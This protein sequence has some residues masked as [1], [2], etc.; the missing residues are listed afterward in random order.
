MDLQRCYNSSE[1]IFP[2]PPHIKEL[3][4]PFGFPEPRDPHRPYLS[5]NFVM[6]LDGR[7]SF[8]ELKGRTGGREVSRSREDRWLMD[9]LRAHHDG[10]LIGANTLRE[11][12]G[13][14]TRGWDFGIDDEQ[15]RAYREE[16]LGLAKQKII[17]LTG[18]GNV[19]VT[20]PVFDSPRVEP[21]IITTREGERT[22]R[23]QHKMLER[24]RRTNIISVGSGEGV[25]LATA[26]ELLRQEHGI[27]TLLCEG[28]P[29]LYGQLLG[30]QL[31]DEEF[32]T[33]SLQVLGETTKPGIERPTTY[34]NV[35][36]S[37]ETAPWFRLI[38]I[39]YALPYHAFFRHR[40]EG[41]RKSQE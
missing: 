7:A 20:L 9:F 35:S 1:D 14:D 22:L 13:T 28:G 3:Y 40:Y 34:G 24:E 41:R 2:L 10:L 37:P 21:W 6:G 38:S 30:E 18:S 19:D 4:G 15:L 33:I 32:R 8:R 31:I 27:R 29:T 11:E 16:T 17:I 26:V 39:H 36:Y 23:A 25:D 5:S 12:P